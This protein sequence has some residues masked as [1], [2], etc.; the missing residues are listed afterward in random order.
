MLDERLL[1][2]LYAGGASLVD[3][4]R[5]VSIRYVIQ[6][7][8]GIICIMELRHCYFALPEKTPASTPLS[9]RRRRGPQGCGSDSRLKLTKVLDEHYLNHPISRF[10]RRYDGPR[11]LE[12]LDPE[13]DLEGDF[14]H[15]DVASEDHPF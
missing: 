9:T 1:L 11:R 13:L 15:W 10:D 6:L 3:S 4:R 2:Y 5:S 8:C 7:H 12:E 14:E